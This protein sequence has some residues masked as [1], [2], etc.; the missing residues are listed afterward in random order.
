MFK[1]RECGCEFDEPFTYVERHGFTHG[2][3]ERWSECPHC[4]SCD[5]DDAYIVEREEEAACER[6][7]ELTEEDEEV[8]E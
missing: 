5:Y 7:R 4:G 2:P 6:E 3:F 1:C 8:R